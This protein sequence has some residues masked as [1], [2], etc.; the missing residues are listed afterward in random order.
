MSNM[1]RNIKRS[2]GIYAFLESTGLLEKG[3]VEDIQRV[4]KQYWATARKEWK[5]NKRK[6]CKSYTIFFNQPELKIVTRSAK[7]YHYSITNFIKQASLCYN[8]NQSIIDKKIV[9]EIR[10]AISL[11]YSKLQTLGEE[12]ILTQKAI[13]TLLKEVVNIET[14]VL[15]FLKQQ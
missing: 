10:E 13:D 7:N 12:N 6:E 11:H 9:G 3:S 1:K 15:S 4:K 2:S 8:T 5:K 14:K